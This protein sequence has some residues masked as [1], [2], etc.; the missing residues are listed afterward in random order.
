MPPRTRQVLLVTPATFDLGRLLTLMDS[1]G[2]SD[3]QGKVIPNVWEDEMFL[4]RCCR[5]GNRL[6]LDLTMRDPEEEAKDGGKSC[7]CPATTRSISM[8]WI[9][10]MTGRCR[11]SAFVDHGRRR[12]MRL[13]T[14]SAHSLST[15]SRTK[16]ARGVGTTKHKR[17][18]ERAGRFGGLHHDLAPGIH[19]RGLHRPL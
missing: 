17:R 5:E 9:W 18:S 15:S 1:H 6:V 10:A 19:V 13:S 8:G 16:R 2:L 3:A 14:P 11:S 4:R 7:T 12:L